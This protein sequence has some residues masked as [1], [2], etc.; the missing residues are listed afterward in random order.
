MAERLAGWRTMQH[1]IKI[2]LA[3]GEVKFVYSASILRVLE[4]NRVMM[5]EKHGDWF[6]VSEQCDDYYEVLLTP[7][8]LL[9]LGEEIIQMANRS[10]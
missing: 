4:E 6:S 8:Q 7:F 2:P 1:K 9:A 3:N 5:V 10:L